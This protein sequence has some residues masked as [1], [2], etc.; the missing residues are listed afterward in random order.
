M[1]HFCHTAR[2]LAAL[3]CIVLLLSAFAGC[4]QIGNIVS[5][6]TT[7]TGEFPVEVAGVTIS[8]RPQ[9]VVVT[10]ASLADVVLALNRETQLV[11]ITEDC[12]QQ[13]LSSLTRVDGENPQAMI[14][15]GA[16][17]VLGESFSDS[18][19]TALSGANIPVLTIAPAVDREDFERLYAQVSSALAGG[20]PGYDAGIAAAQDVF[21]T[22]DDINRIVPKD[23][24][25]TACYLYDLNSRAITGDQ[26]GTTLMSYAGVTN[27]FKSL[28]GGSYDFETLRVS[29]PD[30]IFCL[31][32]LKYQIQSDSRFAEL[33]AVQNNRV[34]ELDESMMTWQGR[35]VI[36]AAYEIS[37]SCFPELLQENS[38][39]VDDPTRDIDSAVSDQMSSALSAPAPDSSAPGNDAQYE[40]LR[41]GDQ[42]EEVLKMQT[43][44][45]ELGYL[46]VE[47]DG[48]Y[49]EYTAGCVRDFQKANGLEETG[50]ADETTLRALYGS[51]AKP[52]G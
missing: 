41:Q 2:C 9:K 26:F 17:L 29:N 42:N 25:T 38:M 45:D 12:T 43:R 32:G 14:D 37:G 40:T 13:S 19:S 36:T 46:D 3:F 34:F 27:V 1:K 44:L 50:V 23:K 5:G 11:G 10:S 16:D 28:S 4:S 47:Y 8:A 30:N 51:S 31:P 7:N 6:V 39:T 24:V 35:T 18:V 22:L 20:G 49:G 48:L 33:H 21:T 15:L 52:K